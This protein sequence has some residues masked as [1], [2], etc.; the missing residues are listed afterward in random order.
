MAYS[1][2]NDKQKQAADV[3]AR[4]MDKFGLK[5]RHIIGPKIGHKYDAD[6]RKEIER[7]IEP[8]VVRNRISDDFYFE[9]YRFT[10]YTLRYSRNGFLSI[11]SMDEHW[12]PARLK[13][14]HAALTNEDTNQTNIHLVIETE[15][16]NAITFDSIG[17]QFRPESYALGVDPHAKPV[18]FLIDK[19]KVILPLPQ[20]DKGFTAH[21]RKEAGKWKVVDTLDDGKLR[22]KTGLQ[23]PIDDAFMDSFLIVKPSE[24][25]PHAK[26]N[27]WVDAEMNRA[28]DQWRKQ[29]RGIPRVKIDK[30]V[31]E[32]DINNHNLILWGLPASNSVLKK[33]VGKLPIRWTDGKLHADDKSY[34]AETHAPILIYPN[35]LNPSKYI[36]LNSGHTFR[37]ES[38]RSNARQTPKLPDWAIIDITT[39]PNSYHPGKVVDA[40]FFGEQ[41]EWKKQVAR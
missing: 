10:T 9:R 28:I 1:G 6:S 32:A 29:F 14:A 2:E 15:N 30:E 13:C 11:Q 34:D 40:G 22:K 38:N 41:W 36:V 39:P 5:L 21:F 20:S 23:G 35:P 17:S 18:D 27:G 37:E 16:I 8:H 7:R 31:T 33:I 12:K 25:S 3:M 24:K 19:Q 26:V 4:E